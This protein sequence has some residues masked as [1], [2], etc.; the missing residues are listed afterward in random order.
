LGIVIGLICQ[1]ADDKAS[2]GP[3]P[4]PS[5]G[6]GLMQVEPGEDVID[7]SDTSGNFET[8]TKIQGDVG[9]NP[10]I[11]LNEREHVGRPVTASCRTESLRISA[12]PSG[13]K[14]VP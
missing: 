14:V 11:V 6:A 5:D 4:G 10:E 12:R 8:E 1:I 2:Q 7:L 9:S 3:E 13:G